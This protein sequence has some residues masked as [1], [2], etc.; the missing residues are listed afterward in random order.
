[1]RRRG[2]GEEVLSSHYVPREHKLLAMREKSLDINVIPF[3]MQFLKIKVKPQYN[4]K[5]SMI[6]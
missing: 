4:F 1:M 2:E 3:E 6:D 5:Y